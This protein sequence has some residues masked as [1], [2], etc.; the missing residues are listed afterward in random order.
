LPTTTITRFAKHLYPRRSTARARFLP[1]K[2]VRKRTG[3]GHS[4]LSRENARGYCLS[5]IC[6]YCRAKVS[7]GT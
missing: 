2:Q 7:Q 6:P 4:T 1:S 3:R 5:D